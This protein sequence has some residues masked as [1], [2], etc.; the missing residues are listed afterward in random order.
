MSLYAQVRSSQK[1]Q[2]LSSYR[3]RLGGRNDSDRKELINL[4]TY[5]LI[6]FQKAFTLAEIL[7][8][9]GIIG[10]VA[11]MTIPALMTHFQQEQT[12]TKLK[13]ALS[14]IVLIISVVSL[15]GCSNSN[16]DISQKS[17]VELYDDMH[18]EATI[19]EDFAESYYDENELMDM[20]NEEVSTYNVS[21]GGTPISVLSHSLET[22]VMSL[23]LSFTDVSH[24][25]K[26]MPEE[27]FIGTV[28]E[29]Y[30]QGYDFNRSLVVVNKP[31]ITIGKNDLMNMATYKLL[32][33]QGDVIIKCPS[34]IL[35]YSQ[36]M[37]LLDDNTVSCNGNNTYFIIYK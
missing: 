22:G 33:V 27:I 16:A 8:T 4:S 18:L 20:V 17:N 36:G 24:Y 21:K 31:N 10:I 32:I 28:N 7:I 13:K 5:P 6:N 35:F 37:E 11:A 2:D 12:V 34:K 23:R 15:F 9:L 14:V 30:Q 25:N 19:V 29:A 26:Y 3:F 1:I